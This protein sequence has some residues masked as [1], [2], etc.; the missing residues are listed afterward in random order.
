MKNFA[1]KILNTPI[2]WDCIQSC[3]GAT[4]W[5]NN[6]YPSVIKKRGRLLDFGCSIGILTRSFLDHEY[7][8]VDI[9]ANV[10]NEARKRFS[11]YDNVHFLCR[12]ILK[13]ELEKSYFDNILF[14][15]TAHHIPDTTLVSILHTLIRSLKEDGELHF[16]DPIVQPTKDRLITRLLIKYDQGKWMRPEN[17]YKTFF[18]EMGYPI[19]EW[20]IFQSPNSFI[21]LQDFLYVRLAKD[22][23][24]YEKQ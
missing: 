11:L 8:G 1:K 14:F 9:D 4:Q 21:K 19:L 16:F 15:G 10:I 5:K 24:L 18:Q 7:Y 13:N 23:Q 3:I 20:R 22:P 6:I 2:I 12:D 17:M